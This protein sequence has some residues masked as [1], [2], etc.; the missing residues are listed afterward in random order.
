MQGPKQGVILV[1]DARKQKTPKLG[2]GVNRELA[3][4]HT[5]Q[6]ASFGPCMVVFALVGFP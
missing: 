6:A 4:I 5:S 2:Q 3:F 1:C